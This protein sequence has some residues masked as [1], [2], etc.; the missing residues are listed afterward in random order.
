MWGPKYDIEEKYDT[1][2]KSAFFVLFWVLH[3]YFIG[4]FASTELSNPNELILMMK[5]CEKIAKK[6]VKIHGNSRKNVKKVGKYAKILS[7]LLFILTALKVFCLKSD[8]ILCEP[9]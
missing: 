8:N 5:N 9:P 4:L 1:L 7:F 2:G 6:N 3:H